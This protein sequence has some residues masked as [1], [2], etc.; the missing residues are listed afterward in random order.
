MP[1]DV[2]SDDAG[3]ERGADVREI[4]K[5]G[6]GVRGAGG[7]N[8]DAVRGDAL[9]RGLIRHR[10]LNVLFGNSLGLKLGAEDFAF[11]ASEEVGRELAVSERLGECDS[12]LVESLGFK[13]CDLLRSRW[14]VGSGGEGGYK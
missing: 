14:L 7:G 12:L 9:I 2:L 11:R 8:T 1:L 5:E 10:F 3:G 6:E 4:D 13:F